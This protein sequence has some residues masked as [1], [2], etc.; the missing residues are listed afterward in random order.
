MHDVTLLSLQGMIQR[1]RVGQQR[2][3]SLLKKET[4]HT[5]R[6]NGGHRADKI[7]GRASTRLDFDSPATY[8]AA[9]SHFGARGLWQSAGVSKKR[10]VGHRADKRSSFD[11]SV[12]RQPCYMQRLVRTSQPEGAMLILAV[13]C[14]QQSRAS[15]EKMVDIVPIR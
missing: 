3:P 2:L 1:Q 4:G 7:R 5:N 9:G 13:G 14:A 6:E 12:F 15:I 11:P 10:Y 8:A